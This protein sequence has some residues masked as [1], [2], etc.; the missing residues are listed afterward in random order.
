VAGGMGGVGK[1]TFLL[2]Y[3]TNTF[4]GDTLLTIGVNF[5]S[6]V[7]EIDGQQVTLLL[8]DLGGQERFRFVQGSYIKGAAA[9]LVFFDVGRLATLYDLEDWF[10]LIRDNTSPTIPMLLVGTKIDLEDEDTQAQAKAEALRVVEEQHLLGY[11]PTSSKS[12]KNVEE[13]IRQIASTLITAERKKA[14]L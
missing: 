5:H 9:A 12:G 13:A 2:R 1:T 4:V 11:V 3:M 14:Q 7:L 8:W 10:K 6:S